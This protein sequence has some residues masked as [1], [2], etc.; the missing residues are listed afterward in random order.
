MNNMLYTNIG[1]IVVWCIK[2]VFIPLGVAV[3][4]RVIV[5]KLL[6]PHPE[7]QRKKRFN[8]NRFK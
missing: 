8:K 5:D 6:K 4:A 7:R 3:F 1:F 2:Y